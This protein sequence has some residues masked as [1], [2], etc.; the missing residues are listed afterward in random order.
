M[1]TNTKI[2]L[3]VITDFEGTVL[4]ILRDDHS[5]IPENSRNL[6]QIVDEKDYLNLFYNDILLKGSAENSNIRFKNSSL[7]VLAYGIKQDDR[8]IILCSAEAVNVYDYIDELVKI[9]T[10]QTN[11][12]RMQS[13]LLTEKNKNTDINLIEKLTKLNND[14]VRMQR[15]LY[16]KNNALKR[17]TE[18]MNTV[19]KSAGLGFVF[20]KI[21]GIV[22]SYND[23]GIYFL[24]LLTNNNLKTGMNISDYKPC[25]NYICPEDLF[26]KILNKDR[27]VEDINLDLW[28]EL[29][30][31]PVEDEFGN[32]TGILLIAEN[33]DRRK[34]NEK[35][36]ES[37]KELLYLINEI[38]RHDLANVFTVTLSA[39]SLYKRTSDESMLNSIVDASKKG[40]G[41]IDRMKSAEGILHDPKKLR[42]TSLETAVH[43]IMKE[44]KEIRYTCEGSGEIYADEMIL[45]MLNNLVSNAKR[46]GNANEMRYIIRKVD[47]H[48][49]FIVAN[50]GKPIPEKILGKVFDESFSYGKTAHTGLGLYIVKKTVE[51][52]NGKVHIENCEG[53]GPCFIFHFPAP[54]KK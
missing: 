20:L 54:M 50:N 19:F 12:I 17:L 16:K 46:H 44:F 42:L 34:K 49:K 1:Y 52:Y 36:I 9:N 48:I 7:H 5:L 24:N 10:I 41:I 4:S 26:I 31:Y 39:T 38:L 27:I 11:T 35:T 2:H 8:V 25:S 45:S 23:A 33:I 6:Y 43:D 22:E 40:I 47:D 53:N 15:D 3:T 32:K 30:S 13:K 29:R 14:L 51:R 18:K 21:N 28:Y 37:Q